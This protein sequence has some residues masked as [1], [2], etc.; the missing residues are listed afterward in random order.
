MAVGKGATLEIDGFDA[1]DHAVSIAN[2][3]SPEEVDATV[4]SSQKRVFE[5]SYDRN[6]LTVVFKWSPAVQTFID[7]HAT[8]SDTEADYI[9]LPYTYGPAGD[10]T[11][12]IK[13]SG[14]GNVV[15]NNRIPG[16]VPGQL[17]TVE[18]RLNLN[19]AVTGTFA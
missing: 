9:D 4:V 17:T 1:H 19:T 16:S 13:I 14:L 11:G 3:F 8:D 2:N 15:A 6:V 10:A 5:P 7:A 12:K 18:F